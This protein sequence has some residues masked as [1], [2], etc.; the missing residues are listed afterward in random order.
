ME[1]HGKPKIVTFFA[2]GNDYSVVL[3]ATLGQS[4]NVTIVR[5]AT[6][7]QNGEIELSRTCQFVPH[8]NVNVG[9]SQMVQFFGSSGRKR[10]A[11][12][13]LALCFAFA[14]TGPG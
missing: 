10:R 5:S 14:I 8:P 11:D 4:V 2:P 3:V 7:T 6:T 12:E 1:R 13:T 9:R